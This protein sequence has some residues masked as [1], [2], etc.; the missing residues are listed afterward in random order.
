MGAALS[1]LPELEQIL[2]HGARHKRVEALR[3]ITA[4][5]LAGSGSFNSDH[6]DVFDEVFGHLIAEIETKARAELANRLAP[7]RNAP[8]NVL[9]T[10]ANDDDIAV[11]GP[12]LKLAPS[13]QETELIDLAYTKSQ[14]HLQAISTRKNLGE[15]VTDVLVRRGDGEVAR[16]VAANRTARISESGFFRL[17]KRAENDGLLAERVGLRPDIPPQL[18]RELLT[19][20]TAIVHE[21]LLAAAP[22]DVKAEIRRVLKKVSTEVGARVG[23]RDYTAAQRVVLG[24][25]RN[26]QLNEAALADM[27]AD[28][29]YEET[30]AGLAVLSKVPINVADRLMAGERPDP[31]LI[32]CKAAGMGWATVKTI[33]GMHPDRKVSTQT[34][35]AAFANYEHLSVSTAQRVVRFWQVRPNT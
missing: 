35:D 10:L 13:L 26:G 31:I 33:I 6:V 9:H 16:T 12:V 14:A 27:A 23:P 8:T 30:V 7:V 1:L 22:D 19:R 4:L 5:F 32:L 29:K 17:V 24:L 34:L 3:R 2:Q 28:G 25:H 11:A 15:A 21:R 18:F 20:A